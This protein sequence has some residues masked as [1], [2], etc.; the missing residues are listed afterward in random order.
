MNTSRQL[1][2]RTAAR[3]LDSGLVS[4]SQLS[5]FCHS[6]ATAG[7]EI[8]GLNAYNIIVPW[9]VI[10]ERALE[11]D[12]RRRYDDTLSIFDGIPISIKSNIADKTLP[13]TAGS[14]ILGFGNN[15]NMDTTTTTT[16]TTT[17]PPC[18]YDADTVRILLREKGGI[19]MGTTSMDEFGM[20]SLGTNSRHP[21]G[22]PRHVK[23]PL[24]FLK[25]LNLN[26]DNNK[27][28][29]DDNIPIGNERTRSDDGR[30]AEI[31]LQSPELIFEKHQKAMESLR[32]E[33]EESTSS[34][35]SSGND[36]HYHYSAGGSSCGSA[37][38]V[39]HGSSLL[40]LGT[41]TGGSVRLPA[42]WCGI[43]GLKPSYGLLSRHGVV[44]YASS[45]DTVGI[46]AK[47][48]DCASTVLDILSQRDVGYSR[49]S[50]FSSYGTMNNYSEIAIAQT[51]IP[52]SS[53]S[54]E[55]E[56]EEEKE[57]KKPLSGIRVGIPSAFSVEECP[58]EIRDS[59]SRAA[60]WLNEN[61]A[62]VMEIST[63]DVSPGLIQR[64]LS[65]YYIL[66]SAEASSNL[67]RYDGFRYGVAAD[68]DE[69]KE[70]G[71]VTASDNNNGAASDLTP[72][73]RQYS[74]TRRQGFGTEV[75]RRILC[76]ASVLS[77]DKFHTHYEAAAQIRAHLAEEFYSVLDEKVDIILIPTVLSLP[78]KIAQNNDYDY[79]VEDS[80]AM[81]A[82]D[83][84][85]VPASLAGLPAVSIPVSIDGEKTFFGGMQ[86]ISSRLG[87][88]TLMK[89]AK[90]LEQI[91]N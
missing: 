60:D 38:S 20:G 34:S 5:L 54:S 37:A 79:I 40:S 84:M 35:S 85:T 63:N 33:K 2:I 29:E 70:G 78:H 9:H 27:Y 41:D 10:S 88:S 74:A 13:L 7:E 91:I 76:G 1:T 8:W 25:H 21:D 45:F 80:T 28:D 49:D 24:P 11:S 71:V 73:E 81:F 46:L 32:K 66:V 61:G 44:S 89:S 23:N 18:G 65:A 75:T 82:N 59:W 4:S 62:D 67:S 48:V 86:L 87:E 72:L 47:S 39:A 53:S 16:T 14:F 43:V 83:I 55:E 6:M 17:T 56:E 26:N 58:N 31:I 12:E 3:L 69:K 52:S 15:S 90:I 50:T 77:S 68:A 64:A 19:M 51:I 42:A 36:Y 57:P 22:S 30:L